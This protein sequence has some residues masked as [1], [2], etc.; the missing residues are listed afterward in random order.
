MMQ[1]PGI[2]WALLIVIGMFA[3]FFGALAIMWLR[4]T[5]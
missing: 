2:V 1:I 4:A 5:W 3:A